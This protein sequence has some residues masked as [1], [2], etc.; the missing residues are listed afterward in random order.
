MKRFYFIIIAFCFMQPVQAQDIKLSRGEVAFLLSV[1]NPQQGSPSFSISGS[2]VDAVIEIKASLRTLMAQT[3]TTKKEFDFPLTNAKQ[4]LC[5]RAINQ[6]QFPVAIAE[7]LKEFKKKFET[8]AQVP[9]KE[10]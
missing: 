3:D 5:L 2:E 6:S 10:E 1:F 7:A 9:E 8:P 4:S